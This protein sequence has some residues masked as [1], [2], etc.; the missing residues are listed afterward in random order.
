MPALSYT[1]F[2]LV[3]GDTAA[4]LSG[5][6]STTATA[7]SSVGTYPVTQG[8]VNAGPNYAI[9]FSAGTLTVTRATLTVTANA[10]TKIYG[11]ANPAFSDTI[12]GFVNGDTAG[13]VSGSASLSTT[14][15][16]GS[17][18]GSYAITAASGSLGAA[19]Y[20]FAFQAGTLTVTPATL[21]VTAN[22]A[23]KTYG[24]ANP[25]FS[26]TIT[27]FVN[28]DTAGVVS[29]S[30][31]LST[32]AT[33]GSGVGSYAITAASGSLSAANYAFAFQA[34]T[35]TVTTAS[36]T[37]TANDATRAYGQANPAFTATFSGFVNG[38]TASS[39]GG[40]L[41]FTTPA[42]A[43][44]PA[45]NYP[46]TPGG[47]TS[48]NYSI[49]FADGSLT[50]TAA[51]LSASSTSVVSSVSPSLYGQAVTFTA[52]VSAVAPATGTPTGTVTFVD[53][54]TDLAT[55]A[56][57]RG[58]RSLHH[59]RAGRGQPQFHG[60][61]Q[62]RQCFR[63]EHLRGTEPDRDPGPSHGDGERREPVVRP[64]QPGVRRLLQRLRQRRYRFGRRRPVVHQFCNGRLDRRHL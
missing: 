38:D 20:A 60:Q 64:G 57:Q 39:L 33:S 42:T 22:A 18:V 21:T 11:H 46:V 15:T 8:T 25:A 41:S 13:V 9:A 23:A 30:A 58:Q 17:G 62:R 37:V 6:L 52:T 54:A 45:G 34:G 48:G 59:V 16:A 56:P 44:S 14:A 3:N 31:S 26:D 55:V 12:T 36:L 24:Q 7:V 1:Y 63:V 51:P 53:G 61:L 43:A 27:G 4:V 10:A 19:N 49:A 35:L 28:G 5:A 40:I 29:G 2:G 47:L 32:A 50:V